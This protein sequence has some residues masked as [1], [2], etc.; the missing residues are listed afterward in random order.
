M[1]VIILG[2]LLCTL[3]CSSS[4]SISETEAFAHDP[5]HMKISYSD[6]LKDEAM[7]VAIQKEKDDEAPKRHCSLFG[8]KL[9]FF[10]IGFQNVI[11]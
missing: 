4:T 2:I 8:E 1:S 10:L 11:D 9:G 7:A 3:P 6:A 5:S